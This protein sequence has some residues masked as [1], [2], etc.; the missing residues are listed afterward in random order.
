MLGAKFIT[1]EGGE[2]AGKSSSIAMIEAW[3]KENDLDYILTREPGGTEVGEVIRECFL[4]YNMGSKTEAL[5]MFAARNQHIETV[6]QPALKKNQWVIC[7]RFTDSTF[8]YQGHARGLNQQALLWLESWIHGDLQPDI[9]LLLDIPIEQ[10]LAR[11]SLEDRLEKEQKEFHQRVRKG[12]QQRLKQFPERIK[13]I[14]ASLPRDEV[15]HAI[16]SILETLLW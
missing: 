5:L 16:Q 15:D 7:D 12:Y 8:A 4:K 10:G 6:I 11:A 13:L 9:T 3:L 14:D 2:G 1:L